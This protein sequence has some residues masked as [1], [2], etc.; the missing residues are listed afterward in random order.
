MLFLRLAFHWQG[1][2]LTVTEAVGLLVGQFHGVS[3]DRFPDAQPEHT[4]PAFS[5]T[6][7]APNSP[8]HIPFCLRWSGFL[9]LLLNPD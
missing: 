1:I 9:F 5:E 2:H 3:Q 6:W 7:Q 8:H 4:L